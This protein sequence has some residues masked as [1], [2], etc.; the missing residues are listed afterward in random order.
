MVVVKMERN[1][2]IPE[3]LGRE[4]RYDLVGSL[5]IKG[6]GVKE[7]PH[8]PGFWFEQGSGWWRR[9]LRIKKC[10]LGRGW[11]PAQV[12]NSAESTSLRC[13][14][15]IQVNMSCRQLDKQLWS[16]EGSFLEEVT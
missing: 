10:V 4:T 12:T 15:D 11:R 14:E 16:S 3:T 5:N 9:F 6:T 13:S 2:W 7:D 1:G 8:P